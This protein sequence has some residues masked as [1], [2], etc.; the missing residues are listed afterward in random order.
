MVSSIKLQNLQ[1]SYTSGFKL[2]I[3]NLELKNNNLNVIVGSNGSGKT[4]LLKLIALLE[5]EDKG[6]II[7]NNENSYIDNPVELRKEIGFLMQNPYLFSVSV[8][9]NIALGLKIRKYPKDEIINRVKGVIKDLGIENL[10]NHSIKSLS[11]GEFRKVA[12]AQVLVFKPN[13]LLLDEPMTN[14]DEQSQLNIEE[15]I[16]DIYSKYKTLI[17]VTTHSIMQAYR[18]SSL[19]DGK[20]GEI[21][22]LSKGQITDF[23]YENVFRGKLEACL[24]AGQTGSEGLKSI[25]LSSNTKII[26]STEKEGD[27]CIAVDPEDIIVSTEVLKSS[28]RNCLQGKIVKIESIGTNV[29]LLIDIGVPLYSIITRQSFEEMGINLNSK[30]FASFKVNSVKVI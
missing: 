22:S 23:I 6:K 7:F 12:L 2:S 27:A 4:T 14:I 25:K 9:E 24:P 15:L 18:L 5:K 11:G 28:A 17:V 30:V 10:V 16:K 20:A 1:K 3:N 13:I 19:P 21:I 29:R 8:F 26:V